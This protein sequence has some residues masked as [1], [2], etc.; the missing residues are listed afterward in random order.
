MLVIVHGGAAAVPIEFLEAKMEDLRQAAKK[1]F[2]ALLAA[3]ESTAVDAVQA[4]VVHMENSG[5][6]NSGFGSSLTAKGEVEMDAIVADGKQLDF[7]A[8][9]SVTRL[10][11]P[12]VAART[13]LDKSEHC[14]F[15]GEGAHVFCSQHGLELVEPGT[16]VNDLAKVCSLLR[17]LR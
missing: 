13:I 17:S 2:M 6:F 4:S 14:L 8:V 12:V 15:V 11:N 3:S 7:G 5:Y 9:A 1:G 16:L 10:R